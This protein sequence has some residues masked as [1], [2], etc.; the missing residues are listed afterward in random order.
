MKKWRITALI[1]AIALLAPASMAS[2]QPV[3]PTGFV[4]VRAADSAGQWRDDMAAQVVDEV[5]AERA[6]YGLS[7]VTVSAELTE[8]ARVRAQELTES[9]SHTRPDGSSWSTVSPAAF[10]ENIARGHNS[11]SRVMAAW[12]TSSGHRRNILR[13]SY[14]AIGVAALQV[15][16]VT[17]WVQLFGR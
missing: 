12:L 15:N 11:A 5:N 13:G 14:T 4:P 8:A 3:C 9:F 16:G 1:L 17:H 2:G 10:A 6:K 7:P